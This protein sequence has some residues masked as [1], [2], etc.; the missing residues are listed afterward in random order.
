[1][2]DRLKE[3]AEL[4]GF[5]FRTGWFT[6]GGGWSI[7]AQIEQEYVDK[8]KELT[9]EELLDTVS[10]GRSL[11]GAMIANAAYL[12][13]YQ[14]GGAICALASLLGIVTP[15]LIILTLLTMCYTAVHENLYVARALTGVRAVV[16]P[17]I[18]S[19][20]LRLHKG[21]FPKWYYVALAICAAILSGA[22]KVSN[23]LLVLCG[24]AA[25][26]LLNWGK[27]EEK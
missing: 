27:K 25:G 17:I 5:F 11:P 6:F 12:F 26:L 15:P 22:F 10:V 3:A 14:R 18:F 7:V 19:A 20:V 2:K 23:I 4:Y 8:R 1:M 9:A 16:A 24:V 21:A 13:G